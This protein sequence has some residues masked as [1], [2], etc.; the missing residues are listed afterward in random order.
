MV[1]GGDEAPQILFDINVSASDMT[2][3]IDV[4]LDYLGYSYINNIYGFG[5]R[6]HLGFYSF[7]SSSIISN[8][9][10]RLASSFINK[11]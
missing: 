2:L 6:Y 8:C 10:N 1:N 4:E 9:D 11:R 5:T 7:T 3:T